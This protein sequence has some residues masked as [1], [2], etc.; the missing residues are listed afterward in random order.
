M[1]IGV[2]GFA[3][4]EIGLEQE[5]VFDC[6]LFA[7]G[8]ARNDLDSLLVRPADRDSTSLKPVGCSYEYHALTADRLERD[9]R[10]ADL[11]GL[12]LDHDAGCHGRAWA[13]NRCL[14]ID[15]SG[16]ASRAC[17][18]LHERADEYDS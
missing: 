7:G 11:H 18:G 9:A 13:P 3:L 4:A 10:N 17:F 12:F 16:Q 5:C 8:K 14:V 2:P 1:L 6:D 15:L